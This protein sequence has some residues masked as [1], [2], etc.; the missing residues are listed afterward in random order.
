MITFN[1][2][3]IWVVYPPGAAG[4][5][6]SFLIARHYNQT[7]TRYSFDTA[8][9]KCNFISTDN[10]VI[11]LFKTDDW[12]DFDDTFF[13]LISNEISKNNLEINNLDALIFS[14]HQ[15]EN[16]H[17]WNILNSVENVKIIRIYPQTINEYEFCFESRRIKNSMTKYNNDFIEYLNV[18]FSD[19]D[20]SRIEHESVLEIGI[21]NFLIKRNFDVFYK[22]LV[23]FLNLDFK[24]VSADIVDYYYSIQSSRLLD[25]LARIDYGH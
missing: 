13:E 24:L 11:N 6:L 18:E 10:K 4:D 14:N 17:V 21:S 20:Y 23:Q 19:S 22:K 5:F 7:G 1:K 16:F 12:I 2:K 15:Y 25:L 3:V 8:T 9:G